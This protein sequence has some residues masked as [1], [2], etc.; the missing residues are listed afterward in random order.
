MTIPLQSV[1]IEVYPGHDDKPNTTD[2][3]EYTIPTEDI[4]NA[5]VAARSDEVM[6][7]ASFTIHNHDGRYTE[8]YTLQ[9]ADRIEFISPIGDK[10]VIAYGDGEYGG[11]AYGGSEVRGWTG[12]VTGVEQTR[13]GPTRGTLKVA[14][15]DYVGDILS[16]RNVTNSYIERDVGYIIRDLIEENAPEVGTTS[17]PDLGVQTDVKYD[18]KNCWDA[19]LE[20]AAR[21]DAITIP[22][23]QYLVIKELDGLPYQFEIEDS[24]IY[25]P[26][27]TSTDGE[28]ENVVRIDSNENRKTEQDQSNVDDTNF[29]R[30]TDTD[31]ITHRLRARKAQ[32]H[33]VDIYVKPDADESLEVRLQSDEGGAPVAIDDSDSDIVS[34]SWERDNLPD[35]E[36]WKTFFFDEHTLADRDPWLII[37]SGGEVGHDIGLTV[38]D[39][40]AFESFYPHPLNFELPDRES[41]ME[42]GAREVRIDKQNMKTL[43]AA[44]DAVRQELARRAWPSKTV[45]M[46]ARSQRAHKLTPGDVV[47]INRPEDDV[48]GEHIVSETTATWDSDS[49]TLKT[50]L[51]CEWRKGILAPQS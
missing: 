40:L 11:G 13:D 32:V 6:D 16:E 37:Q 28:I 19:I 49:T 30:V 31:R 51:T 7:E 35:T 10:E 24:D 38:A 47:E 9:Q 18:G 42:Y 43:S 14:A 44:R 34:A 27:K 21:V 4:E 26:L 41:V 46:E 29:Q 5:E 48:T 23:G 39:E 22:S 25:L 33:S 50:E 2:D 1:Y 36:G 45:E 12:R 20:L 3:P 17:I 8:T 15:R